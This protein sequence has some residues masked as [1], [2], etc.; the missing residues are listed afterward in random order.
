MARADNSQRGFIIVA[1]LWMLAALATLASVY[2]IYVANTAAASHV[3]DDRLQ[4]EASMR[5]GVELAAAKLT[6]GPAATRPTSGAFALR[7]GRSRIAVAFQPESALIDLNKAPKPLLSGLFTTIGLDA[8]RAAYCA[9]RIIAWRTKGVVAA[10]N[11]EAQAYRLAGYSYP[12][13]QAPFQ[14]VLELSLVLG[15]SADVVARILPD[16]TVFSGEAEVDAAA[17]APEV[18]AALPGMTPQILQAVLAQRARDPADSKALNAA[19]GPA[20][21]Q[22]NAGAHKTMR[23]SVKV[24]LDN[25]RHVSG[26]ASILML[27]EADDPYRVL[28]WR[29]DFDGP[30]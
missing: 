24:D 25:G 8:A 21:A 2:A 13:R 10:Q 15:L 14:N 27:E 28:A 30:G 5:A 7:L 20:Q 16:V 22:A 12:P 17:A 23:V 29:D 9:D 6:T 4:A 18:L 11:D 26:V 1:V 3:S 19:L